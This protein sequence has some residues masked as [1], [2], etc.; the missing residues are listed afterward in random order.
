MSLTVGSG[1]VTVASQL[2]E[3]GSALTVISAGQEIVGIMLST[4]WTS[5]I[6]VV[7]FPAWSITIMDTIIFCPTS[8]QQNLTLWPKTVSEGVEQLDDILLT[9]MLSIIQLSNAVKLKSLI[10]SVFIPERPIGTISL[11]HDNSGS[12]IS[13]TVTL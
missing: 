3:V 5:N 9:A 1:T 10:W 6:Q 2:G 7:R 11:L 13:T 4:T 12:C 8:S